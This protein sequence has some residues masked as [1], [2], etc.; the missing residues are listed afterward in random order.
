MHVATRHSS[1]EVHDVTKLIHTDEFQTGDEVRAGE[2]HQ[3]RQRHGDCHR[4]GWAQPLHKVR[5]RRSSGALLDRAEGLVHG[6]L[7]LCD[8]CAAEVSTEKVPE[9][10]SG[11]SRPQT[12][13]PS[14]QDL[15][16]A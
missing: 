8:E 16:V 7:W 6:S 3:G 13:S 1:E 9:R 15:V 12:E 10:A 2:A 11:G 14:S 5:V 4:C